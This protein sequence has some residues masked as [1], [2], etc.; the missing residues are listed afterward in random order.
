MTLPHWPSEAARAR[1][2]LRQ[3]EKDIFDL[4]NYIE[5][6]LGC[7]RKKELG[8]KVR[9]VSF[10]LRHGLAAAD[11]LTGACIDDLNLVPA[12][13]AEVDLVHIRHRISS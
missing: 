7:E 11:Q 6:G 1:G 5:K 9:P 2:D 3:L 4:H 8:C 10:D 12:D 13:L